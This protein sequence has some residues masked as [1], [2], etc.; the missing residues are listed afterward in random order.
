RDIFREKH[1]R[2]SE[3]VL[4]SESESSLLQNPYHLQRFINY[5]ASE[6][7]TLQR[8]ASEAP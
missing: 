2:G 8:H 3:L 1:A 7:E 4:A 5:T 6:D